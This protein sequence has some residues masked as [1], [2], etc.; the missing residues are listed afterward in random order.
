LPHS[1]GSSAAVV[2]PDPARSPRQAGQELAFAN[3]TGA[4][5]ANKRSGS[6]FIRARLRSLAGGIQRLQRDSRHPGAKSGIDHS[7]VNLLFYGLFFKGIRGV[8]YQSPRDEPPGAPGSGGGGRTRSGPPPP[9]CMRWPHVAI[10][11]PAITRSEHS[12]GE[13]API[14]DEKSRQ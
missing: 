4:R 6:V 2:T 10:S 1:R 14:K 12:K 7:C 9:A 3:E 11:W 13:E 8:A 5:A